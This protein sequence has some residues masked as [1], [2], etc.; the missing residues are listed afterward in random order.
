MRAGIV[1]SN[2]I[3]WKGYFDFIDCVDAFVLFDDVQFTRRDWRNRNKIKTATGLHWLTIPVESKGKYHQRI[4]ET[5]V[6][7][8]GW[9]DDHMNALR[10]AYGR[11]AHFR[12]EWPWIEDVF[13]ACSSMPRLSQVN[14]AFIEAIARRLGI[15]TPI[16]F[17]SEFRLDEGKNE[18]L[19]GICKDLGASEYI[20]GPAARGYIDPAL[21]EAQG[22]TVRYK[23]YDN[24]PEYPQLHGGFEHGV[25]VLDLIFNAGPEAAQLFR[26]TPRVTD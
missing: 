13:R 3:P 19:I 17:S 23:G 7:D 11:A 14:R 15:A 2:Y 26:S 10:H 25:T 8:N 6:S 16:H 22:I 1:Q 24:Y 4:D 21:W 20:S 5:L 12:A 9:I 18:H